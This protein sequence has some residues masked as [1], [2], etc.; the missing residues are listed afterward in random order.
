MRFLFLT[1]FILLTSCASEARRNWSSWYPVDLETSERRW[2]ICK[3]DK[4]GPLY[5]MKG[6]CWSYD[7]CRKRKTF[8]GRTE[9]ECRVKILHCKWGD[10]PCMVKYNID[11]AELIIK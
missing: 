8:L 9:K 3:E 6:F 7:E 11:T 1:M 5:H 2:D 10:I 4:Y